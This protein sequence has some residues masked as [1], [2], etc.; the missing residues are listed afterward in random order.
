MSDDRVSGLPE[1]ICD[2]SQDRVQHLHVQSEAR[3]PKHR[4]PRRLPEWICGGS[5]YRVR[6]VHMSA[7]SE[8]V[9]GHRLWAT[10][11]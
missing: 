3:L 2:G 5:Q 11:A 7:G 8:R 4:V 9:L 10:T 1:W 6:H